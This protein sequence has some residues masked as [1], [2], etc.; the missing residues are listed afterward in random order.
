MKRF[1]AFFA[2]VVLAVLM[3]STAA[4]A[5]ADKVRGEKGDGSVN[6][7]Q[8]MDPPPFEP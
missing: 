4:F 2:A 8:K 3:L 5:G 1:F 6:Q 7:V